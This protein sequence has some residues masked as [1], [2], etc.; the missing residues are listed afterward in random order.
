M[1]YADLHI[2]S[3]Y[4]RATSRDADLE[5]MAIWACK[6][7]VS[8]L[9]TGDFTHPA[10]FAEIQEKLV[11]AEPGLFRLRDDLDR[12]AKRQTPGSC[13]QDIRFMLEVEISTIYKKGDKTRKVHH[14]IYAPDLEKA[15]R[16]IEQLARIGNLK[17]DGRPILGLDSRDLLE[18]TLASGDGCYLVP[19]HIW[20]PW[21][22]AMGS[23]SG[24]DSIEQCYGDLASHIFAVETG[25]SSDPAMNARLSCLDR[26]TLVSNSDAHSPPKI[27]REACAFDCPM[28]YFSMRQ[29]LE[30]GTGYRGTVEFFPEEGK[31]HMDGHRKCGVRLSPRQTR[32][33][34][35]KCPACGKSLTVGVLNR[36]DALADRD[37]DRACGPDVEYRSLIPLPEVISEIRGV[38]EKS[39]RVQN[40]YEQLIAK[41]GSEL[42][43]LEEIPVEDVRAAGAPVVAEAIKRMRDGQVIREAGYDGEYGTIRL[44]EPG[45]LS[46]R[47]CV[48]LLFEMPESAEQRN[49]HPEF[50]P[51]KMKNE[52]QQQSHLPIRPEVQDSA[53]VQ[54]RQLDG[55]SPSETQPPSQAGQA[56]TESDRSPKVSQTEG[57]RVE[58]HSLLAGL[59]DHQREAAQITEGPLLII[60]GPGTGKTRTLTHR[61][62]HIVQDHHVPPEQCLTITFS[63]RAAAEMGE[64]LEQLLPEKGGRIPVMTFHAL[65]LS[66]LRDHHGL[67]DLPESF[68]VAGELECV[69]L[70][71]ETAGVSEAKANRLWK[72]RRQSESDDAAGQADVDGTP[73]LFDAFADRMR[74]TGLVDFDSLITLPTALLRSRPDI[75]GDYHDQWTWISID[76]FQDVD[77]KQYELIQELAPSE[78]NVCAIGDPDQSIYGFRGADA[79]AFETFARDYPRTQTVHLAQ[80]YRSSRTIVDAALQAIAPSSLV[81]D[82]QLRSCS[83]DS[84][85]I[86][87]QS[88]A[89]DRAEAEFVVHS[90]ERLIGGSTFFSLDSGRVEQD[91]GEPLSFS[92]I[93]VLYRTDS[94]ADALSEAFARS[95]IPYQRKAHTALL[96]DPEISAIVQLMQA[97]LVKEEAD[98]TISVCDLL[99]RAADAAWPEQ[100]DAATWLEALFPLA[101]PF[102]SRLADFLSHLAMGVDVD[103]WDPRADRISLLTLHAAKGLEFPVVFLTGCEDQVLPLHWGNADDGDLAEERRLFFV[104]ITRARR[105]LFLSHA[106]KRSWRGKLRAMEVSPL[107]SVIEDELLVRSRSEAGKRKNRSQQ[108]ALFD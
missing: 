26:F 77:R 96:D 90:V 89:T 10:W 43:L 57:N 22:A 48:S 91:E 39:K 59:D 60:A 15:K 9:G 27:G 68:R 35:G 32:E 105:H 3:K 23:K 5:H 33:H 51:V 100:P 14:L 42:T 94:Q 50:A 74:R 101:E 40:A 29:A 30:T 97:K 19:A 1:F 104:G 24:F 6:K 49:S 21:F 99:K 20:T 86:H 58:D 38:G 53:P 45:E 46:R 73:A 36:I 93:G 55:S 75:A 13:V 7:G 71:A 85:R 78:G 79:R 44:F 18:I 80:N 76:E 70:L 72:Q 52:Q 66:I 17:S 67:A 88:C 65:G 41:V 84:R 11:P 64:R 37:E 92:D 28:D 16:L 69:Q 87:I 95:G 8:V 108:L 63:R 25:L 4:S 12:E 31:Y 47:D 61:L 83:G 2:H 56:R 81:E 103:L 106:A 98:P 34:E 54:G 82:R 102:G 62:A 107:L